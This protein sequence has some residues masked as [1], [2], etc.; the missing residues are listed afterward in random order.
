MIKKEQRERIYSLD[1]MRGLVIILMALDHVRD[2]WSV[3]SFSPL[4]L[5]QTYPEYFFTRWITHFCAPVFV[6]LAGTSA[7]LYHHKIKDTKALSKFLLVRG[8]WLIFIEIMV[9]NSS[10]ALG[11]F[12][13]EWGFTLQVIWA[14]GIGMIVMAGLVYF[15]DKV[16]LIIGLL[17]LFGHNLLNPVVPEDLGS[18]GWIWKMLHERGWQSLNEQGDW[19]VYF[20]Y[21]IIPWIGVMAVGYVFGHIMLFE[22]QKRTRWLLRLS[23]AAIV[24]FI[25]L[26]FT[27]WYGDTTD[28]QSQKTGLFTLMS[29]INT[30]KYP[31]SLLYLLMTLGPSFL[32]LILFEKRSTKIFEILRV[33][34]RVPFFFYVLHFIFIHLTSLVYFKLVHGQW[35]DLVS[36]QSKNWPAFYEPSLLRLYLA[37]LGTIVCFYFI[38]KWYD[39]Y[40]STHQ[41]WWLKYL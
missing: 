2:F 24:L 18:F 40:K 6:F 29:F 23:I 11:F 17:I 7:F 12:W 5:T 25:V 22:K 34:G 16:I 39:R 20:A 14:L 36:T 31:P 41:H 8:L 32:L 37:W 4:D 3:E 9:V 21:P 26:R 13:S 35:F 27:N 1:I 33:F 15:S 30:Q 28:W 10:W 38:C 19:G